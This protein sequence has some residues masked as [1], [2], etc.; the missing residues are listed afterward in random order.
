MRDVRIALVVCRSVLGET[1]V[2]LARMEKWTAAAARQGAEIICFPELCATGYH[3]RE[4]VRSAA[5]PLPGP[6]SDHIR[7]MADKHDICILAGLA[8]KRRDQIFAVHLL[9]KPETGIAG[10]YRKLH[11]G[12]PEQEH[13]TAGQKIPPLPE[14]R[15][16]RLGIQLCY[17]THFPELSTAMAAKGADIIFMPH[18]SPGKDAEEKLASWMR[19]LPARAFD[20]G[21]YVAAVNQVGDNDSGLYFP[22]VAALI[23]PA[24][25]LLHSYTEDQENML[26][27]DLSVRELNSVREHPMR[28]FLPNRRP[29]LYK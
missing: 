6:A 17:D 28:Y 14:A 25:K 26:L 9:A 16:I 23:S 11:L 15:G 19:H 27:A 24:G 8:E 4:A 10:V 13:F 1:P 7:A 29:E 2:N 5:Q 22:G 3:I 21:V 18:A 12:P 20:N